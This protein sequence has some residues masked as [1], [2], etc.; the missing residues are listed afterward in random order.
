MA[1]GNQ[2]GQYRSST[3]PRSASL[4]GTRA[5]VLGSM[6]KTVVARLG[7]MANLRDEDLEHER[8]EA[9]VSHQSRRRLAA[10]LSVISLEFDRGK[11]PVQ[12]CNDSDKETS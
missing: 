2:G 10:S 1:L 8:R 6:E 3:R 5:T 11:R 4:Q 12:D 7:N 9:S